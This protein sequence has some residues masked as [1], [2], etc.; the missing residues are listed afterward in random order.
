MRTILWGL[1]IIGIGLWVWFSNLGMLSGIVFSRD[2]PL[3]IVVLGL[4]SVGE[5]ISWLVRRRRWRR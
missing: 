4:M 5:G 2:W 1:V 3:I